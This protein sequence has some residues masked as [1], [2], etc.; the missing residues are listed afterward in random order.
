M[1]KLAVF[2]LAIAVVMAFS[3][4]SLAQDK[5]EGKIEALSKVAKKITI[6]GIEYSLTDQAAQA[7]A[8]VGDRVEAT[9]DGG[10]VTNL[11]PLLLM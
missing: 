11:K 10:V 8:K 7:K 9:V 5:I 1:R 2:F 6:N 4:T 3:L